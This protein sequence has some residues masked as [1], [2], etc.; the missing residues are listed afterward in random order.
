MLRIVNLEEIQERLLRLPTLVSRLEA[1]DAGF[2]AAVREWLAD[3]EKVLVGNR[4]PAAGELATLRGTLISAERGTI[5]TGVSV[6]GR[7]TPRKIRDAAA[8]DVLRRAEDA[9]S[10]AVRADAARVGEAERLVHQ[11]VSVALR[12][13]ILPPPP[14]SGSHTDMLRTAWSLVCADPD[15]GAAATHVAG[16]VGPHDALVLLDRAL[17]AAG[18]CQPASANRVTEK[19]A[20]STPGLLPSTASPTA[21]AVTGASRM[22]FR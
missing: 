13:G 8:A 17:A 15:T 9:L 1:R 20:R 19:G 6:E 14:G 22:P 10:D 21:S 2:A 16:L 18:A 4:I 11:V 12:K 5:P 3:T 7:A